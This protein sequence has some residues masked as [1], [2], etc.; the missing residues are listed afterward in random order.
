MT[1]NQIKA[2]GIKTDSWISLYNSVD[3]ILFINEGSLYPVKGTEYYFDSKND[4][5][6]VRYGNYV[7]K[8]NTENIIYYD[9]GVENSKIG[10]FHEI[11][12]IEMISMI[13]LK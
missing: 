5:L 7:K 3:R 8:D 1:T 13:I 12:D 9:G 6:F 4:L 2:F 10:L 11:Y